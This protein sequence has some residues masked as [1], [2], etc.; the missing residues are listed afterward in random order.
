MDTYNDA[1]KLIERDR[2]N[3]QIAALEAERDGLQRLT[4]R[5]TEAL[6]ILTAISERRGIMV[7]D[8]IGLN[9]QLDKERDGL[10]AALQRIADGGPPFSIKVE[11]WLSAS[12]MAE[13]A[14]LALDPPNSTIT[15]EHE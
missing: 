9:N 3:A 5:Q 8:L 12:E 15:G 14:V 11:E 4:E 13:I 1:T 6:Q 2:L 7:T 10:R